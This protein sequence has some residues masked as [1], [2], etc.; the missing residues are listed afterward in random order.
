MHSADDRGDGVT[1]FA[2]ARD[3]NRIL[4][5]PVAPLPDPAGPEAL[6]SRRGLR[7]GGHVW[8][9]LSHDNA[10]GYQ[11][12]F[13]I[14]PKRDRQLSSQGNQHDA[15][16]PRRSICGLAGILSRQG[17]AGLVFPPEPCEFDEDVSCP[18]VAGLGDPLAPR[19]RAAVVGTRC[20]PEERTELSA[21]GE[22]SREE[23]ARQDR[24]I[25]ATH[26]PQRAQQFSFL[27]DRWMLRIGC[28]ALLL[29]DANLG[30]D[31]LEVL[32]CAA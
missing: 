20:Q 10:V 11:A 5:L 13:D 29:D 31:Q 28:I 18:A 30:L 7:C 2:G 27:L 15:P 26:P 32:W 19:R 21:T 9:G 25:G 17:T 16:D 14:A 12:R 3:A 22:L 8:R 1:L 23:L 6:K 4:E 24:C